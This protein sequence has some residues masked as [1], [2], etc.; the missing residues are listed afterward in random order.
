[1]LN[2]VVKKS[3]TTSVGD[4]PSESGEILDTVTLAANQTKGQHRCRLFIS[5]LLRKQLALSLADKL[6]NSA[7]KVNDLRHK[8]L[9]IFLR[10]FAGR[11]L[12]LLQ[13]AIQIAERLS[14]TWQSRA[15]VRE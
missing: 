6:Q 9:L 4:V 12:F 14:L 1:M 13:A 15:L 7:Q 10:I 8:Q 11:H 2:W 5:K 3:W